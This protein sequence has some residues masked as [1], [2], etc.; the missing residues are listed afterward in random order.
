MFRERR[1][2]PFGGMLYQAVPHGIEMDVVEVL[3]QIL[4]VPNDMLP[5]SSLPD[6]AL[7]PIGLRFGS[8]L[9]NAALG[10]PALRKLGWLSWIPGWW[11]A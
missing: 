11:R 8:G 5:V 3:P 2:G 6:S 4:L 10:D 7:A 1:R 9:L